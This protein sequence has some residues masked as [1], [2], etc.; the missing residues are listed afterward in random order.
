M[1]L[2]LYNTATRQKEKFEPLKPERVSFYTCGP[3]VYAPAHIGNLR[4]FVTSDLCRRTLKWNGYEVRAVMNVT[5]VD[6]KTIKG[7]EVAGVTLADFTKQHEKVFLA[8]LKRLNVELPDAIPHATEYIPAMVAMIEMLISRGAAYAATDGIYFKISSFPRYGALAKLMTDREIKSRIDNDEY[9]K[10]NAADFALWKFEPA[11]AEVAWDAPFG[12][13]R[14]GWHIECSAMIRATLG[15]TIDIHLGGTDLIFPHHENEIAQSESVTGAPLARFWLHSAFVNVAE[16]KM[17]KS[18]NNILTLKNLAEKNFSPLA[19]RY[20]LLTAHYRSLLNFTWESL[21]GAAAA[22]QKLRQRVIDLVQPSMSSQEGQLLTDYLNK[23]TEAINDDLNLPVA[24]SIIWQLLDDHSPAPNDVLA[25]LL[26]FDKVLGL[27]LI[28]ATQPLEIPP[29]VIQLLA[30]REAAR[31]AHDFV[32]ADKIRQQI[33]NLGY[34][35]D[36]TET[37]AKLKKF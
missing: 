27:D 21:G 13:G 4:T 14:P 29:E 6:D 23:F 2:T 24:V 16:N 1:A 3:T 30:R 28:S 34:S 12:R 18:L 15:D 36:D 35:I 7:S 37:G 25:T 26:E 19:Y 10:E 17:S 8:D 33:K 22:D 32:S 20:L 31:V 11:E 5:D 9:D